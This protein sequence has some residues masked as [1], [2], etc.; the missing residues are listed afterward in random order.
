MS[1]TRIPKA[2]MT[3]PS[4]K[5]MR[6]SWGGALGALL[7]LLICIA[8][9]VLAV[10]NPIPRVA[11]GA[12]AGGDERAE[13]YNALIDDLVVARGWLEM[14]AT[15]DG[16]AVVES[17]LAPTDPVWQRFKRESYL[18]GDLR[19]PERWRVSDY[20]F[21]RDGRETIEIVGIDPS[22]HQVAG[23]FNAPDSWSG[24][25]LYRPGT[26]RVVGLTRRVSET[27]AG[28]A[29]E[30]PM[31]FRPNGRD[32][33]VELFGETP[34]T[35]DAAWRYRF[36]ATK[37]GCVGEVASV[38]RIG[39][40]LRGDA[41]EAAGDACADLRAKP[42]EIAQPDIEQPA[43]QPFGHMRL[44]LDE[45]TARID[46]A[47]A[48]AIVEGRRFANERRAEQHRRYDHHAGDD[49]QGRERRQITPPRHR[50]QQAQ[51]ER[52]EQDGGDH[53]PQDRP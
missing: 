21:Q 10:T 5:A 11:G 2:R 37:A 46:L 53:R 17:P 38:M 44:R 6:V 36:R 3:L 23:P 45:D 13:G 50:A 43:P 30:R 14:R 22:A 20:R 27:G 1:R 32:G 24:G 42:V 12:A 4:L 28:P 18:F 7:V 39:T 33:T 8:P 25:L 49:Q 35:A 16:Y 29:R 34:A 48:Q 26:A 15:G 40:D 52:V 19:A 47:A 31:R 9:Q 41:L 51:I